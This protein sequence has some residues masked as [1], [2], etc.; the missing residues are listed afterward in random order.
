[1]SQT[2]KI[3]IKTNTETKTKPKKYANVDDDAHSLI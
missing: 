1:M 2:K 3:K